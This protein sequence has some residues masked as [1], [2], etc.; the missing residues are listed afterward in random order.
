MDPDL[1]ILTG[2][3]IFTVVC[4]AET[5]FFDYSKS[6]GKNEL[7]QELCSRTK[8]DFCVEKQEWKLAK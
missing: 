2:I 3:A 5:L 1:K 7:V 8:Y 4:V 6:F